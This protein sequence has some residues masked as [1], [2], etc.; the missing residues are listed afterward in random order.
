MLRQ[1]MRAKL[2]RVTTTHAEL[3][4]IGSCA[5]DQDLLDAAGIAEYEQVHVWNVSNGERFI[6]YAMNA[7]R[8]SGTISVNG[9]AARRAQVGD[10]LIIAAFGMLTDAEVATHKPTVIFVDE[11]NRIT[12]H[13]DEL[14]S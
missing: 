14:A 11:K 4:Y 1:F 10:M 6:T 13:T 7:P 9:S 3:H 12:D 2:H 8:G 5:I